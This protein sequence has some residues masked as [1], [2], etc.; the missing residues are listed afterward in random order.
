MARRVLFMIREEYS[1]KIKTDLVNGVSIND[2]S[3]I[4]NTLKSSLSNSSSISA[5]STAGSINNSATP[6]PLKS[7]INQIEGKL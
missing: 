7:S 1:A 6:I 3:T 4:A 5:I 2:K